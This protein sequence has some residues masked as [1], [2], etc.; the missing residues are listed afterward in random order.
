MTET[1]LKRLTK[2]QLQALLKEQA[3]R[4]EGASTKHVLAALF[5]TLLGAALF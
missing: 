1:Q 5:G 2:A 3:E 4:L